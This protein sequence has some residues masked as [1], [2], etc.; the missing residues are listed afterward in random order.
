MILKCNCLLF[1]L[2]KFVLNRIKIV[3]LTLGR[4]GQPP[5]GSVRL[6]AAERLRG[7][8]AGGLQLPGPQQHHG[9]HAGARRVSDVHE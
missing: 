5:R 3:F 4:A 1:H 2:E 6:R 7:I 9:P 8:P